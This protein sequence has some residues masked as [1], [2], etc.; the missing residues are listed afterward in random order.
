MIS[1][2]ELKKLQ[3]M[4]SIPAL[5]ILLPTHR[6]FPENKQDIDQTFATRDLVY[7]L[8]RTQRFW[9]LLLSL[10]S[11]RLFSGY[12]ETLIEVTD[13]NF[14]MTMTGPGA[15]EPVG[16]RGLVDKSS[17]LDERY[18][19]FFRKVDSAFS[20]YA[21]DDRLPLIVG[22]VERQI[23]FF[24]EVS[25]HKQAIIGSITGN[26]DKATLPEVEELVKPIAASFRQEQRAK[27]VAE[28]ASA[29][30]GQ[31][32]VSTLEEAWRLNY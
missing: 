31:R 4:Q 18:V 25:T 32:T 12:G 17:Y 5:S 26:L 1:R 30:N 28:L 14:P 24:Q 27:A 7:G 19:Q 2:H 23:S 3:S 15:N 22:G 20:E 8:H 29:V 21:Q 9:V 6:T 10:S 11:S 16:G 13:K